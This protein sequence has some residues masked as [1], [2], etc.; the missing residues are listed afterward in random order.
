MK[1][2]GGLASVTLRKQRVLGVQAR[3]GSFSRCSIGRYGH[4]C[5]RVVDHTFVHDTYFDDTMLDKHGVLV[6]PASRTG[7][8]HGV[9]AK[10]M[11]A[12]PVRTLIG[13]NKS[14]QIPDG[15]DAGFRRE[16]KPAD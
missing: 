15:L 16:T 1:R 8:G 7:Y 6:R 3:V 13:I 2:S 12:V 5:W 4:D 11:I 14:R 9:S 10:L